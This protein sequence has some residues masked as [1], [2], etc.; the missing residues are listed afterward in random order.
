MHDYDILL[1]NPPKLTEQPETE[2]SGTLFISKIQKSIAMNPGILSIASY[3]QAH[4][5]SVKIIDLS[6][7]SNFKRLRLELGKETPLVAGVGSISGLD[8]LESLKCIQIIKEECPDTICIAGGQHIG[9]LGRIALED[10]PLLDI[11][12]KY[13]GEWVTEQIIQRL[14]KRK[15]FADLPGIVFYKNNH[16]VENSLMPPIIDLNELPFMNFELYP[17]FRKFTP[18]VEES[19]GCTYGCKFCNSNTINGGCVRIKRAERFAEE[20]EYAVSLYGTRPMYA[21]L[22]STFGIDYKNAISAAEYI[23]ALDV[24]WTTEFRADSPWDK[25]LHPIYDAGFRV[26]NIGLES[27]SPEILLRMGKTNNPASYLKNMEK[28]VYEISKIDDLTLRVNFMFYVGETPKTV[29]ETISFIVRNWYGIDAIIYSPLLVL[30]GTP[31]YE[32]FHIYEKEYGAMLIQ[33]DFWKQRHLYLC[34]P[35]IYFSLED[36]S[37]LGNLMEKIFSTEEG[38]YRAEMTLYSQ[39]DENTI[40]RSKNDLI[41]KRFTRGGVS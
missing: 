38:W 29:R 24:L 41:R 39:E 15:D 7:D 18:F 9:P 40:K 8:Y 36:I 1:V 19:R 17:N 32:N 34:H 30:Y 22:A 31:L 27:A 10:C 25:F 37:Y 5:F 35:S 14:K 26:C 28:L 16:L 13:E 11:V 33:T 6:M 12:V 4:N 2:P 21:V 3:L 20:M 23:K